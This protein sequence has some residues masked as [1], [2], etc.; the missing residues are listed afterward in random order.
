MTGYT[1]R[2]A[3]ATHRSELIPML[4]LL[5][6]Q[7]VAEAHPRG[8]HHDDLERRPRRRFLRRRSRQASRA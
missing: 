1:D 4:Y 2:V 7:A 3:G 8:R 5:F 6:T